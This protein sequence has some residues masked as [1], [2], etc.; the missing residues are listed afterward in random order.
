MKAIKKLFAGLMVFTLVLGVSFAGSAFASGDEVKL[1]DSEVSVIYKPGYVGFSGDIE[2]ANLGP[3]KNV[4]V[5]Y[6]TDDKTWYDTSAS[7]VGPTDGSHEKWRFSISTNGS[8]TEHA[9]LKDLRSI[10][11][12][13]KYEVNNQTYW[14]N[15]GSANYY[16]EV[17]RNYPLRSVIL[18]APNV[19]N[20]N[21]TLSNGEFSGNIYVKN[22]NPDKKVKILYT[23]DDW[24]TTREAYA[25]YT[26]SLNNFNSVENWNYSIN[27]PGATH[28]K[29][30]ISYTTA[31]Q[32][33]W[34]NNYGHNYE[35]VS[36]SL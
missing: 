30:A 34:D 4:T 27:V 14:D 28:V 20:A 21:S 22:L 29:Y 35:V 3:V 7:Y 24:A 11:F 13:I 19:L 6:T 32:T 10:K 9:E 16:N 25:V 12:A 31:G 26:G 8:T 23:T 5:H 2:V 33:Y 18:G 17:N 1:I 36:N 15:N